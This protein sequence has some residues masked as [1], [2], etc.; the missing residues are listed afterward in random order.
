MSL[1]QVVPHLMES[2]L[3]AESLA[4]LAGAVLVVHCLYIFSVVYYSGYSWI[5][6]D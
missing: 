3:V 5:D 1:F 6:M 2:L 4:T